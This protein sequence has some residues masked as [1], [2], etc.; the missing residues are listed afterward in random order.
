MNVC[1]QKS[2]EWR[3]TCREQQNPL[4]KPMFTTPACPIEASSAVRGRNLR[5]LHYNHA[6]YQASVANRSPHLRFREHR[7]VVQSTS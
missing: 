7:Q 6:L 2:F 4:L 3:I 1:D 5:N